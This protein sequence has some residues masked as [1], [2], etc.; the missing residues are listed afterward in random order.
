MS[1]A[2]I[3]PLPV[4]CLLFDATRVSA[5]FIKILREKT[6]TDFKAIIGLDRPLGD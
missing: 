5:V 4:V 3:V 6:S 2:S 1:N